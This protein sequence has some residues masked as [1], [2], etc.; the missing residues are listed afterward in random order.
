MAIHVQALFTHDAHSRLLFVNEPGGGEPAPR[1][2][3][4]RTRVGNLW[5]FRADLP[6]SLIAELEALCVDEPVGMEFHSTPRHIE[7]YVRRTRPV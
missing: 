6:E 4:G 1:L 3:F 2:F 7:A 5:R